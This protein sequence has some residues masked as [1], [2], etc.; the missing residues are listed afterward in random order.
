MSNRGFNG[1]RSIISFVDTR[2]TITSGSSKNL[3]LE[4]LRPFS[5][6]TKQKEYLERCFR[7][8]NV[9]ETVHICKSLASIACL[10][11]VNNPV[12]GFRFPTIAPT[13]RGGG[14]KKKKKRKK[15][16]S[17]RVWNI[18]SS[19]VYRTRRFASFARW[20]TSVSPRES[21]TGEICR[22]GCSRRFRLPFASFEI[23]AS[24][25]YATRRIFLDNTW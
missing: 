3:E 16:T 8:D 10:L 11:Q 19:A 6:C 14:K 17:A 24:R 18:H 15:E 20:C 9:I 1:T 22:M 4:M 21:K 7:R 13:R 12:L 2:I 23:S 5:F 25:L